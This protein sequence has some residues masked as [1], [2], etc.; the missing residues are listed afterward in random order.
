[1]IKIINPIEN[2]KWLNFIENQEKSTIFHHPAWLSVL[3]KQYHFPVFAVC[4]QDKIGNITAGIPKRANKL[5]DEFTIFPK[6][7]GNAYSD[8][9]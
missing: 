5:L 8:I 1:M 4:S 3:N 6:N 2:K 7:L 9:A